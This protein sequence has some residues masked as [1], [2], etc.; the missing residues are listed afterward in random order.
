MLNPKMQTN[1][2][3]PDRVSVASDEAIVIANYSVL[4]CSQ[5]LAKELSKMQHN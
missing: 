2:D 4:P 1:I 3:V 5:T